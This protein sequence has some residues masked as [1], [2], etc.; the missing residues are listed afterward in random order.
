MTK[1][2]IKIHGELKVLTNYKEHAMTV[3]RQKSKSNPFGQNVP[4]IRQEI[5]DVQKR[6]RWH[7]EPPIGPVG[8]YLTYKPKY[9]F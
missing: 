8:D 6:G 5:A 9:D 2:F 4:K 3:Q 1:I 7:G